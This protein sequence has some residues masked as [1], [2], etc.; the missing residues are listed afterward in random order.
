M[1]RVFSAGVFD[2]LNLGH[3]NILTQAKMLGDKLIIGIQSDE[4]VKKSK[5]SYPIL[6][7]DERISQ[8]TAFPFV[9]DIVVYDN[10]D[11][12]EL[13]DEIRP[14]IIVQGDDYIHSGDRLEALKYIKD[15]NIRLVLLPRT[16]GISS[17]EIKKRILY[18]DR[19][20]ISHLHQLKL[21]PIDELSIYEQFQ[22]EKVN[23]LYEKIKLEKQFDFP[24]S[25]GLHEDLNIV[26]DGVNRL[27]VLKRLGCKFALCLAI[28][29]NDIHLTN[30]IHYIKENK[31]TR[32]SEFFDASGEEL[33]FEKRSHNDIIS[34]IRNRNTIPNGETWHQL[35]FNI[36]NFSVPL[37]DLINGFDIDKKIN[38]MLN[39]N[40]IRYFPT[41]VYK[42]NEWE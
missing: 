13:W 16:K 18:T 32:M 39:L 23:K 15:H 2:V 33:V 25:V 22:E 42:C 30:N 37:T 6:N 5:G 19:K 9:T 38:D 28:P 3:L 26:V 21:I 31:I 41:G 10:V 24:I 34:L 29:Y 11:Q 14:D 1:S 35:P 4:S 20:D 17:T 36:I 8:I 12:R 7:I 40:N 27:E